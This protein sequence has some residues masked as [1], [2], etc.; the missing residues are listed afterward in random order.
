MEFQFTCEEKEPI[1]PISSKFRRLHL[2]VLIYADPLSVESRNNETF[3]WRES[4]NQNSKMGRVEKKEKRNYEY[5]LCD[6]PS[7]FFLRDEVLKLLQVK[8]TFL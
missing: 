6:S 3:K 1:T 4:K 8:P 2:Y 7:I 5:R